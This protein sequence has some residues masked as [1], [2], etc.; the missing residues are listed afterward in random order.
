MDTKYEL[1]NVRQED[2]VLDGKWIAPMSHLY[3]GEMARLT[4]DKQLMYTVA[5]WSITVTFA[6]NGL[7]W[8]TS[9]IPHWL[10]FLVFL[11]QFVLSIVE[12]DASQHY[13]IPKYRNDLVLQGFYVDILTQI[14][15]EQ[16]KVQVGDVGAADLSVSLPFVPPPAEQRTCCTSDVTDQNETWQRKLIQSIKSPM[17]PISNLRAWTVRFRR[18]HVYLFAMTL[19]AW[20]FKLSL[21]QNLDPNL[22]APVLTSFT[23]LSAIVIVLFPAM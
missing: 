16:F 9:T 14:E 2:Y 4:V 23:L 11:F 21:T 10:H 7:L 5:G 22:I 18:M 15:K 13:A 8:S 3:R 20:V 12:T 6:F 19:A 1:K 17:S